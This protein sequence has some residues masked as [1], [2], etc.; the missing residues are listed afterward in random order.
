M[1]VLA[2]YAALFRLPDDFSGGLSD[3]LR[4]LADY[5]ESRIPQDLPLSAD[6]SVAVSDGRALIIDCNMPIGNV[7]GMMFDDFI[8][9]VQDG[10]RFSGILE[11]KDFNP[12][13][14]VEAL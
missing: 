9:L 14:Q 1:R 5:H 4:L 10:K 8:E 3:A 6:L 12:K 7:Q 2:I 11:F 13:V